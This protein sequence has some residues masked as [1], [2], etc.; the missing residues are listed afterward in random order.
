[1]LSF[2]L[3]KRQG[4]RFMG[5]E[6]APLGKYIELFSEGVHN[7]EYERNQRDNQ[8]GPGEKMAIPPGNPG[9]QLFPPVI[10]LFLL[11]PFQ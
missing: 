7:H 10:N 11:L 1:M 6:D 4:K 2:K 8:P 3:S 9:F 5:Q